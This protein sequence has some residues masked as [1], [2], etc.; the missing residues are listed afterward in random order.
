MCGGDKLVIFPYVKRSQPPPFD[1][2]SCR[3]TKGTIRQAEGGGASSQTVSIFYTQPLREISLSGSQW[4][5][6]QTM[7]MAVDRQEANARA[8]F[9]SAQGIIQQKPEHRGH[10]QL[11]SE[12]VDAWRR[13]WSRGRVEVQ[14]TDAQLAK[15]TNFAQY[16][17]LSALPAEFPQLPPQFSEVYYGCSR[18]S[19]AK[20]DLGHDY[21]GHVMWDNEMY[22]MPAVL[23]FHPETVKKMLR[24][25]WA[26]DRTFSLVQ[27]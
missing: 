2:V 21:Q 7:I 25:R 24:Y 6:N 4:E 22:L 5:V 8:D 19:L 14:G 11:F 1:C 12:H 10:Y 3:R 17:I 20:G 16:Y 13:T 18:S 9:E 26:K 27:L 23:P 15:V